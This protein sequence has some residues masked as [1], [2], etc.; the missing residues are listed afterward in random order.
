MKRIVT[1]IGDVFSVNIN[2]SEKKYFQLISF[3]LMQL[4][5][6]V[7]RVFKK[8]YEN[9]VELT[10]Q[11]II[12]DEAINY[13][14]C[15]TKHGIKLNLWTKVGNISEVGRLDNI[16]FRNTNDYGHKVGE[17]PI[18]I[19]NNWH[20]WKINAENFT[21]VGKLTGENRNSYVGLVFNPF[22]IIDILKGNDYLINYPYFE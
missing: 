14:H 3:D 22:D 4:N 11:E 9:N 18:K 15:S 2:E 12:N 5:S 6:D 8:T 10:L 20:I 7:I 13:A 1:K 21:R 16:I 17:E 19:S